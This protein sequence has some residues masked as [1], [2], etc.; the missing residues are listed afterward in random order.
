METPWDDVDFYVG[1]A[2]RLE[3][4]EILLANGIDPSN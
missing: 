1:E 4:L 3:W 2:G